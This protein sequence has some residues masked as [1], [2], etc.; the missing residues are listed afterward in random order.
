MEES[1]DLHYDNLESIVE[2]ANRIKGPIVKKVNDVVGYG[3]FAD[4][5]Y[6]QGEKVTQY[7]GIQVPKNSS[8]SYIIQGLSYSYNA[9][10]IFNLKDKGRWINDSKMNMN[11]DLKRKDLWFLT[12]KPVKKGEEFLWYRDWNYKR[13][14]MN[15]LTELK[16]ANSLIGTIIKKTRNLI[17]ENDKLY[18][19]IRFNEDFYQRQMYEMELNQQDKKS[20]NA[21]F[22]YTLF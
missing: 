1:V 8:G 6:E 2:R 19:E 12:I 10:F 3:L 15:L 11:V 4:R 13:K 20:I 9:E 14:S 7:G 16:T 5:D 18:T 17:E 22:K 21:V